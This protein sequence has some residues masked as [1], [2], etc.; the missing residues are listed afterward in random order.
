MSL[1]SKS[2]SVLAN[3]GHLDNDGP[4]SC[5][6]LGRDI[7]EATSAGMQQV[8]PLACSVDLGR[9]VA[10]LLRKSLGPTPSP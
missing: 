7:L 8:S 10:A 4:W 1:I 2:A 5:W 6:L 3:H 9:D